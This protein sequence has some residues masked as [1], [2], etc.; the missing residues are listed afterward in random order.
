MLLILWMYSK[1][2]AGKG[3]KI[4]RESQDQD[5][6]FL[7]LSLLIA[8]RIHFSRF[9][10]GS[11]PCP[12]PGSLSGIRFSPGQGVEPPEKFVEDIIEKWRLTSPTVILQDNPGKS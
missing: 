8:L 12:G 11:T 6:E 7:S 3:T 4:Q 10:R 9:S 5:K 2:C 1:V